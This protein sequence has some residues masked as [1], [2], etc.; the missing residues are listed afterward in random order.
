M[1]Q[2]GCAQLPPTHWPLALHDVPAPQVPQVPPQP[3]LPHARPLQLG[4]QEVEQV[5][6]DVHVLPLAQVP[7][8][9]PQPSL[10]HDFPLQL[11]VHD[12]E[13]F[14]AEPIGV[15]MPVGPSQPAPALQSTL[16]QLPFEPLVTSVKSAMFSYANDGAAPP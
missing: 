3:S 8:V 1:L 5:P 14:N 11:G 10:P 12:V 15:P 4:V 9:P 13:P 16:P 7:Q 2:I 6:A